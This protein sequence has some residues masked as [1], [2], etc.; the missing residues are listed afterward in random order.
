MALSS[1]TTAT[2]GV[3]GWIAAKYWLKLQNTNIQSDHQLSGNHRE[4]LVIIFICYGIFLCLISWAPYQFEL[5]PKMIFGKIITQSNIIPFIGHFALRDL[6]AA[7]DLVKE[8][9]AFIPAGMLIA[10]AF[11]TSRRDI[12]RR[13]V[14]FESDETPLP[15]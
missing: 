12:S 11:S 5:H 6:S 15:G 10:F 4:L 9:G 3:A 1:T 13:K 14:V 2:P 8:V 7:F